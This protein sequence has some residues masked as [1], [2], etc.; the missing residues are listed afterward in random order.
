MSGAVTTLGGGAPTI[1]ESIEDPQIFGSTF[2]DLATWR[3]WVAFLKSLFA[4]PMDDEEFQVYQ[5]FTGRTTAP[6]EPARE[7]WLPI[8]RRGGKSRIAS[9]IAV[10]VACFRDFSDVLGPGEVGTVMLIASD[11]RQARILYRYIVAL[12]EGSPLLRS[13]VEEKLKESIRLTNNIQV[14]VHTCSFKAVRGYSVVACLADEIAFWSS[15]E[16]GANPDA[17]VIAAIRPGMSSIPGAMLLAIS[18]PY[19]RRGA[20]WKAYE[21]H[22]GRDDDPVLV[23]KAGTMSMNPTANAALIAEAYQEDPA[24]AAS[25]YGGEFRSDLES[26]VPLEVIESAVVPGRTSLPPDARYSPIAFIDPSGGA[27]D[28]MVLA[29]SHYDRGIQKAVLDLIVER[30]AP[31]SPEA[32]C[33]EF[34]STL[35][36]YRCSRATGD[37]YGGNWPADELRKNQITYEASARPKSDLYMEFLPLL[38]SGRVQ[39]LDNRRLTAQLSALERRTGRSGKDTVNHP[40][41][42]FDDVVNACVGS[43]LL[44]HETGARKRFC[45]AITLD[46]MVLAE[47][48]GIDADGVEWRNGRV[49]SGLLMPE[50]NSKGQLLGRY[51]MEFR[52]GSL[53]AYHDVYQMK[54]LKKG[55]ES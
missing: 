6:T 17:E 11:R 19:S 40:P 53:V 14:E 48:N 32:V 18:S 4:L 5:E 8:G 10:Y 9:L 7:A 35:E 41:S 27:R 51:A 22:H 39:L 12:L 3:N 28:S 34:A 47:A 43:L 1:I 24:R 29:I 36:Q 55:E 26:F 45:P 44:A 2:R 23:W 31:F 54:D 49:W 37:R 42:G 25:E 38:N 30:R 52:D 20:L 15:D 13:M 16:Y 21:R 46:G 33:R 50:R